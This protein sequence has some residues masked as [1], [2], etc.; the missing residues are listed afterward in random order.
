[1]QTFQDTVAKMNEMMTNSF[2]QIAEINMQ[3]YDSIVKSQTELANVCVRSGL[4]QLEISKDMQDAESYLNQQKELT[5]ETVEE[6][7]Q[8]TVATVKQATATRD[9]VL[10]W[11]E[12]SV[13]AAVSLS[14]VSQAA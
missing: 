2:K 6:L 3:T 9:D 5:Q 8:F 4:K 10:D 13:K 12:S 11:M 7:Q 14:P 1:M